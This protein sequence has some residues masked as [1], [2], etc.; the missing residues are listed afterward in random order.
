MK[1]MKSVFP[2]HIS[3]FAL[4]GIVSIL[5]PIGYAAENQLTTAPPMAVSTTSSGTILQQNQPLLSPDGRR[6]GIF[7]DTDGAPSSTASPSVPATTGPTVLVKK[8]VLS[9]EL[10]EPAATQVREFFKQ[11]EG[12]QLSIAQIDHIRLILNGILQKNVDLLTY[13]TLPSQNV[14]DGTLHFTIGH[15]RVGKVSFDNNQSLV[16]NESL[17][18]Y[19]PTVIEGGPAVGV[20]EV[21]QA[22][23]R[24]QKLPGVGEV[25]PVLTPGEAIGTTQVDMQVTP[26]PRVSG[27]L[28]ADN[29]GS[30][31]SGQ[32]RV[33][34]QLVVNS[35]LGIGDQ[36]QGV[37]LTAPP[38][39]QDAASK[40]GHTVIGQLSYD[41]PLG[42]SGVRGG[43][44]FTHVDYKS[45]G[46]DRDILEGKGKADVASV[47]VSKP[48][49]DRDDA[50]VTLGATLNHKQLSDGLFG[51]TSKRQSV[52]AGAKISGFKNSQLGDLPN[53]IQFD[54]ALESGHLTQSEFGVLDDPDG[55][56]VTGRFTK[57]SGTMEYVQKIR[58]GM[59]ASLKG[60]AQLA[61]RHL[62]SSEQ[63]S[64]GGAQGVR[65][66]SSALSSVDQG[67]VVSAAL[68]QNITMV[69][70]LSASAFYDI[71]RGQINKQSTLIGGGNMITPQSAGIGLNYQ[72]DK[73]V[74]LSL[75]H[76]R[77]IGAIP[78]GQAVTERGQTW[79]NLAVTF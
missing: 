67:A 50:N 16:S 54:A 23:R 62:D 24:I 9:E 48:L 56:L 7:A 17:T 42:Y 33:G 40:G 27:A 63:M 64:L 57:L 71:G 41:L 43:I 28:I 53:A 25:K 51:L 52:T 75:S 10:P 79:L 8:I 70:G 3:D 21:E 60:S 69:Q 59:T 1:K 39:D 11:V 55:L 22:T 73:K 13:A 38:V 36:L 34:A 68:T 72:Y 18:H 77:R 61:S 2:L 29:A 46:P 14:A 20:A 45:G 6:R 65:G 74:L 76:H 4:A 32:N 5:S 30:T 31:S 15:G 12:Q 58:N 37:V 35:P 47:N 44:Q 19:F 78:E 49:V 26:A 66:Y